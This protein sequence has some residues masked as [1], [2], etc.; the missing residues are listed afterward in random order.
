M[1]RSRSRR[2]AL[3]AV[4]APVVTA[5]LLATAGPAAAIPFEGDPTPTSCL[6][7]GSARAGTA[8]S[9]RFVSHGYVLVLVPRSEC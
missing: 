9:S 5:G 8:G 7:L 6:R 1:S 4:L 3:L 2:A